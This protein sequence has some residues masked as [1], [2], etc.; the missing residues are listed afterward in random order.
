[1]L[2]AAS[3]RA[4]RDSTAILGASPISMRLEGSPGRTRTELQ[5]DEAR[6]NLTSE[7]TARS[8]RLKDLTQTLGTGTYSTAQEYW[9]S[10]LDSLSAQ[11]EL[12][13]QA[14]KRHN[15][16]E[17][18]YSKLDDGDSLASGRMRLTRTGP[19]ARAQHSSMTSEALGT[20]FPQSAPMALNKIHDP[21]HPDYQG[22]VLAGPKKEPYV[23]P[24]IRKFG[25]TDQMGRQRQTTGSKPP[26]SQPSYR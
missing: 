16:L 17:E 5:A 12:F 1:M 20:M 3:L 22:I 4:E 7:V 26:T 14:T 21:E 11:H 9:K 19:T 25:W 18:V 24:S 6:T 23:S 2:D 8:D 15:T 13:R 10:E